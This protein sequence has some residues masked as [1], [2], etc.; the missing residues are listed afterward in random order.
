[1][2][3]KILIILLFLSL[4]SFKSKAQGTAGKDFWV[5]YM[6]HA[7][8]CYY[9]Y[10]YYNYD[11]VELFLSS[12][13]AATVKIAAAGQNFSQTVTLTP[14]ITT[15]VRLPSSVV[16]RYSDSVTLNGVHVTS[17]EIINVY[18]VNRYW[19]SKGATV[20][21]P[22][23]S[24]VN[25]PEYVVTTDEDT[26]NWGWSCNGK[27]FRSAEFVIVGIADSSVI[28]VVPTGASTRNSSAG[29]PFQII[30]KKGETFQYLSTDKDLT[31]SIIR[32]KYP[33]S[34]YGVFAGNRLTVKFLKDKAGNQ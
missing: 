26:Y 2:I 28:E 6:A 29:V 1:M 12:Q 22:S 31:G 17:N 23:E 13:A 27:S 30:L 9:N 19:F 21:I 14:N 11:T 10:N 15:T 18:A 5:G 3:K 24:I 4:F 33:L 20:V 7:W 32:S 25:S 8:D 16:C 34:K